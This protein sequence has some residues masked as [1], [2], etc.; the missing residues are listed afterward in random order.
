[1][2]AAGDALW[3]LTQKCTQ[4]AIINCDHSPPTMPP[5]APLK[6]EATPSNSTGPQANAAASQTPTKRKAVAVSADAPAAAKPRANAPKIVSSALVSVLTAM[7]AELLADKGAAPGDA[8]EAAPL[9]A[10]SVPSSSGPAVA[11]KKALC[12]HGHPKYRCKE[13]GGAGVCE[14]GRMRYKCKD[15][16]GRSVRRDACLYLKNVTITRRFA[17]MAGSSISARNARAGAF[18]S[19]ER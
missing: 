8:P 19:T 15:C 16:G 3:A 7:N 11:P 10:C 5:K 14:H 1:M 17:R 6:S 13:C 18:A 4:R 12:R 9:Q 2:V